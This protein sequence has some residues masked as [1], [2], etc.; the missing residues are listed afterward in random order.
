[1][2]GPWLLHL[3]HSSVHFV[4]DKDFL[5]TENLFFIIFIQEHFI[6]GD[7]YKQMI[8]IAK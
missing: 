6:E 8:N 1:M 2:L 5:F 7:F 4:Q 3:Q